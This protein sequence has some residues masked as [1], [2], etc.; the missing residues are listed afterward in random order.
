MRVSNGPAISS[1]SPAE[2]RGM[3]YL[4][5]FQSNGMTSMKTSRSTLDRIFGSV[6]PLR[7]ELWM[8]TGVFHTGMP[9]NLQPLAIPVVHQKQCYSV[10]Y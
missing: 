9:K 3:M 6:A 10:V 5:Q 8:G 1:T 4:G 7:D 2:Y